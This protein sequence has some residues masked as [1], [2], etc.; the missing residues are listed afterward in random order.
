MMGR[1]AL[2]LL[3]ALIRSTPL[4]A[5]QESFMGFDRN[6]YPGDS[7]LDELRHTFRF[8]SYWLNN[9]PGE[10]HNSWAGKRSLLKQKGFGFL[11][12]FNG[13]LDAQ[14]KNQDAARLGKADGQ[15]AVTTAIQEGFPHNVLI[16]L[17]Q[18]EGGRLMPEQ[19]AYL[20][21]WIDAVREAGARAGIYCSGIDVPDGNSTIS[22]AKDILAQERTRPRKTSQEL[23]IWIVN[24]EC[25]PSPGCTRTFKAMSSGLKGDNQDSVIVWQYALSPRRAQFA[26]ACPKNY[27]SDGNCYAPGLRHD[28]N[29]FLD[30]DIARSPDPSEVPF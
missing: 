28:S 5:A 23:A 7:Y 6:D 15:S 1:I 2:V 4:S 26:A 19:S 30:L 9:P 18:E 22:I 20:F 21:A 27:D 13:R 8:T 17:D 12:L 16:F 29:T 10:Q 25:P 14:L 11:V 3:F 24:D